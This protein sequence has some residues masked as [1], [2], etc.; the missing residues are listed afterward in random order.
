MPLPSLTIHANIWLETEGGDVALSR[1]RMELLKA[2]DREGSISAAAKAMNIQYR[3]AWQ[4]IHDMEDRL[5][6]PL[7]QT[8]V[9]GRGGGGAQLTPAAR[10]LIEHLDKLFAA[11][12]ACAQER[13]ATHLHK[14]ARAL[15]QN[16]A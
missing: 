11:I 3:L 9:G 2:V 4:R 15:T 6:F 7:V 16:E 5:G 13:G 14:L 10:V 8:T 12:D 1:W